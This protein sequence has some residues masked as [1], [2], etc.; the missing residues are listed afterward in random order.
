[1][2]K[3]AALPFVAHVRSLQPLTGRRLKASTFASL[4]NILTGERTPRQVRRS[5][6][7]RRSNFSNVPGN[8]S[9]FAGEIFP[10]GIN[11]FRIEVIGERALPTAAQPQSSH[12][13]SSK[14][15]IKFEDPRHARFKSSLFP[16]KDTTAVARAPQPM[17][18][19]NF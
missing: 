11:F 16:T 6:Q 10:I 12:A 7:F 14:K 4:T 17:L 18:V 2:P 9:R 19:N 13:T 3:E 5:R 15:F 1:L 8:E